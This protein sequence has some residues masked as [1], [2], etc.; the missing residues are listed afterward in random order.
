[1]PHSCDTVIP[2]ELVE[3]KGKKIT[4]PPGQETGANRRFAGECGTDFLERDLGGF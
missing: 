2:L 3:A 1:M 4:I